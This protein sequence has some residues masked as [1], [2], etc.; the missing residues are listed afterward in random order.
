MG[1]LRKDRKGYT[2][3]PIQLG[4]GSTPASDKESDSSSTPSN[5]E[6]EDST[7]E[8]EED[9]DL[10]DWGDETTENTEANAKSP[11]IE[12]EDPLTVD[13]DPVGEG[14]NVLYEKPE[15]HFGSRH[16]RVA[17]HKPRVN[18]DILSMTTGRPRFT[19]DCVSIT[20]THGDPPSVR[21]ARSK[22]Y[23][24]CSDMSTHS[25][26]AIDWAIGVILRDGDDLCVLRDY[27]HCH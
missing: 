5:S 11:A 12:P 16:G 13:R 25:K 4:R 23:F 1:P 26:F 27:L 24:V 20:I 7:T 21:S 6:T 8:D 22:T 18:P 9:D 19:R 14:V 3:I 15:P 17:G 2:D 10:E